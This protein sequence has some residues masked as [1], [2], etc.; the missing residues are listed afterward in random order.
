MP[1]SLTITDIS[2]IVVAGNDYATVNTLTVDGATWNLTGA[3]VTCSIYDER[4]MANALISGLSVA[5]TTA[6]SGIVTLTLTDNGASN[7]TD[8]LHVSNDATELIP[9]IADFKVVE[10]DTTV[11]NTDPWRLFVRKALT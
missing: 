11:T 6:A 2:D 1:P 8:L 5:L 9:H 10:A 4:D 7:G 3:T